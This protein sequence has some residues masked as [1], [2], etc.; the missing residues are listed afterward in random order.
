MR[1]YLQRGECMTFDEY[2][3]KFRRIAELEGIQVTD[4][5]LKKLFISQIVI[6]SFEREQ[7]EKAMNRMK[8][9]AR[10]E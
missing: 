5:E 7:I 3:E 10:Y 2:S 9:N 4:D 1:L 8:H 6:N